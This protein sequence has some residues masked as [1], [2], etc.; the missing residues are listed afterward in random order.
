[1]TP[2]FYFGDYVSK[3]AGSRLL[4]KHLHFSCLLTIFNLQHNFLTSVCRRYWHAE[5]PYA[6][7]G[8]GSPKQTVRAFIV[9]VLMILASANGKHYAWRHDKQNRTAQKTVD[10]L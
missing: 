7:L 10:W 6:L 2:L 4:L 1:M 3:K 5:T 9:P 8:H